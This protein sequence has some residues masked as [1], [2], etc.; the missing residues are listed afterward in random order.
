MV[1][2]KFKEDPKERF[3][4]R[5]ENYIK[6]RPN[7]PQQ[8]ISFLTEQKIL[9]KKYSVADIGSGTGILSELFLKNENIVYGIE[10]NDEMR[11]AGEKLLKKYKK[12]IS[13]KGSAEETTLRKES[14]EIVTAGQAFHW[15]DLEKSRK[16]FI[17]ILKPAG[18]VIL[19]WNSRKKESDD[20]L[21]DYETFLLKYGTDYKIIEKRKLDFDEF[22]N[23]NIGENYKLMKFDNQQIFDFEGLQGRLLSTSYIPL[24][25]NSRHHEMLLELQKLFEKHQKNGTVKFLYK[26]ELYYGQLL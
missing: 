22:Y 24:N 4:S 20:F 10:P 17:R 15:F 25:N 18:W 21:M 23:S 1:E 3:S 2:N 6:Y 9:L 5:V 13:I 19:I 7:Y 26:T 11:K 14:V 12:Y 8:I 16:E